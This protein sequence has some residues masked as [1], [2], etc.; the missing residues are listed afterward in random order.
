MEVSVEI[1]NCR[2][3]GNPLVEG[4]TYKCPSRS[5]PERECKKC[6][7]TRVFKYYYANKEKI[8]AQRRDRR[9]VFPRRDSDYNRKKQWGLTREQFEQMK[10]D[11]GGRC[12]ICG[13]EYW[14]GKHKEAIIDHCH[15]TG[16][17]RGLLCNRCN[18]AMGKF[19]D[20]PD[21]LEKVVVYLRK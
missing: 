8:L 13:T 4:E 1:R 18:Q 11:Q 2:K 9:R 10:A 16:K 5:F 12:A 20:D 15:K 14:G 21:L 7:R 17:I 19:E 6:I 3:C